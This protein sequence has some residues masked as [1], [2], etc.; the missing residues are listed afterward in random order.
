[1]CQITEADAKQKVKNFFV[2]L[3][4]LDEHEKMQE[5]RREKERHERSFQFKLIKLLKHVFKT[6]CHRFFIS[7]T[8]ATNKRGSG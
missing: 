3:G 2:I 8:S 7:D 1:M 4:A 5:K 6:S